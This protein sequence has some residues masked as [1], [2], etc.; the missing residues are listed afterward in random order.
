MS[1]KLSY[2]HYVNSTSSA[3]TNPLN[4]PPC[5]N[6]VLVCGRSSS[7]GY[8]HRG[9]GR[10]SLGYQVY[11]G[12][13]VVSGEQ[14]QHQQYIKTF[15]CKVKIWGRLLACLLLAAVA[16]CAP[17]AFFRRLI[18]TRLAFSR[19]CFAHHEGG[20]DERA[21]GVNFAIRARDIALRDGSITVTF[22]SNPV[23]SRVPR[24]V[25]GGGVIMSV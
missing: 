6:F 5:V 7:S 19:P 21:C 23:E 22:C 2:F 13:P 11:P 9:P 3:S 25:G 8:A 16:A 4:P 10:A 12:A 18:P 17:C 24:G 14:H 15:S 1:G 20:P